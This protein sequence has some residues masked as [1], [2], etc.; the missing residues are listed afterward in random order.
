MH[1]RTLAATLLLCL[2]A[3]LSHAEP[4]VPLEPDLESVVILRVDGTLVLSPEGE[5]VHYLVSTKLSDELRRR[6]LLTVGTWKFKPVLIDGVPRE[7]RTDMRVMLAAR[8]VADRYRIDV[9]NV[10]FPG[11]GGIV[12]DGAKA[13]SGAMTGRKLSPP[14]YPRGLAAANIRGTVLLAIRVSPEGTAEE[15]VV[16]QSMLVD[17]RGRDRVMKQALRAFESAST[18]AAIDWTFNISPELARKPGAERTVTVPIVFS[19][20]ERRP[21][22]VGAD[23]RWHTFVRGPMRPIS[24]Q[25]NEAGAQRVGVTDVAQGEIIPLISAIALTS[26][27]V[28]APLL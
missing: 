26:D 22:E 13:I 7:V 11:K 5:V 17:V 12:P 24:W 4:A 10:L 8:P 23:G 14:Q 9:D 25:P 18:S 27:V 28:G 21:P 15:V 6:L 20:S 19:G 16:T 2:V 1:I 3:G